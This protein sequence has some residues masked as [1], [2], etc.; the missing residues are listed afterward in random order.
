MNIYGTDSIM[1]NR[2]SSLKLVNADKMDRD[3]CIEHV[4]SNNKILIVE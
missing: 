1:A 2:L 3:T 4:I